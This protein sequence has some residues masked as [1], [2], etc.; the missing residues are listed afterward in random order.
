MGNENLRDALKRDKI[1]SLPET[2]NAPFGALVGSCDFTRRDRALS[3]HVR[4]HSDNIDHN[5]ADCWR[6]LLR[7]LVRSIWLYGVRP[8]PFYFGYEVGLIMSHIFYPGLNKSFPA[9][10]YS[11]GTWVFLQSDQIT[12]RRVASAE[13]IITLR[14]NGIATRENWR[15]HLT[16]PAGGCGP[17]REDELILP[18]EVDPLPTLPDEP[19]SK[20]SKKRRGFVYL[21]QGPAGA[22][23]IGRSID[24]KNR[25]KTF[26]VLLPFEVEYIC[27]LET[28]DMLGLESLLHERF[29]DKRV[30][31]EW[32]A[33]SPADVDYIKGL[34]R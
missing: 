11:E 20:E 32:F 34:A 4:C 14:P 18:S 28:F 24:P 25:L 22:Y 13:M 8:V 26:G 29:A 7:Q 17:V 1:T 6:Q 16:D 5:M 30:N 19:K 12:P 21:L 3:A 2:T 9:P 15:Y 10:K 23:K 27:L 33:L 31:G